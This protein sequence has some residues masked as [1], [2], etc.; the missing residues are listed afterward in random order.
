[1]RLASRIAEYNFKNAKSVLIPYCIEMTKDPELIVIMQ[2]STNVY[3]QRT[4]L[5]A[6]ESNAITLSAA[7][8][9]KGLEVSHIII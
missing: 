6:K 2:M 4:V 5:V 3:P 1:M 8:F 9:V 7:L